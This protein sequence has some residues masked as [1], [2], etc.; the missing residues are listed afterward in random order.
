M[1]QALK[2]SSSTRYMDYWKAD[3]N[4][5]SNFAH[6][7]HPLLWLSSFFPTSSQ[8]YDQDTDPQGRLIIELNMDTFK[9]QRS[10]LS[11][12]HRIEGF[13]LRSETGQEGQAVSF[14][15][16]W[17]SCLRLHLGGKD[18]WNEG[19]FR[20]F[21]YHVLHYYFHK[22]CTLWLTNMEVENGP[23]EDYFPLQTV[24]FPLP[25]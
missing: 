19:Y 7:P 8:E 25:C 15:S 6:R 13:L 9:E 2:L 21:L 20:Y 5:S 1:P 22:L 12:L 18:F 23:L 11:I 24:G 3:L 16:P 17:F 10:A 14:A 4:Q